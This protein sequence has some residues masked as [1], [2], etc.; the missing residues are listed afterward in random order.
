MDILSEAIASMRIGRAEACW[1]TAS[2][3][4]GMRYPRHEVSGFHLVVRGSGW[5][6]TADAPPRALAEG[7]VVLT[8][9]G[10]EHGLSHEPCRLENLPEA[11]MTGQPGPR[12]A[13]VELLC[14][15]Y[16]LDHGQVHHYLKALPTVIAAS[17]DYERH[18]HLRSVVGQFG[19]AVVDPSPG[20]AVTRAALL[21]LLLAQ[22]L[23]EQ[24]DRTGAIRPEVRDPA[25]AEALRQIHARP[26]Q[27][28]TVQRLSELSGMS[29]TTFTKRFSAL[30]GKNPLAYQTGWR[31]SHGAALLRQTD[32]P[33]AT[34]A[35]QVGYSTEFAFSSAFRRAYGISPGRFR[36]S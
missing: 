28:W 25:I 5:L 22:V 7:D 2:G 1:V 15:A 23:R 27:P 30:V 19:E 12:P 3:S 35:R 20:S 17:L 31:L 11:T 10:A 9:F 16:W 36:A 4:W 21:D 18:P 26:D 32:A 34:I 14:G 33:L 24:L 8:P 13:E 6:I 29:R